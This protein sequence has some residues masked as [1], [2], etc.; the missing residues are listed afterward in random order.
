MNWKVFRIGLVLAL[1]AAVVAI[2]FASGESAFGVFI[3]SRAL[4]VFGLP[5]MALLLLALIL[6]QRWRADKGLESPIAV[7]L[8]IAIGIVILTPASY[9]GTMIAEWRFERAKADIG[10]TVA[11]LEQ[12]K[13]AHGR[14]PNSLEEAASEGIRVPVPAFAGWRF[15]VPKAQGQ[16]FRLIL[17][18]PEPFTEWAFD[19]KTNEWWAC[20]EGYG[21]ADD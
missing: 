5:V 4:L 1:A 2:V 13:S 8:A 20:K 15:Y 11:A 14:F 21:S 18:C 17:S 16:A 19:S 12:F 7:V 3:L 6:I 10:A 9:L